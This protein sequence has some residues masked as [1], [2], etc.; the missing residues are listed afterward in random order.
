MVIALLAYVGWL[1]LQIMTFWIPYV[2]GASPRWARV[3]AAN[4]AQTVQWL[5]TKGNHLP[6]DASHF[7]L[8]LLLVVAIVCTTLA[9]RAKD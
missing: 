8:Q 3:H 4:F 9:A 2:Q 7:V 5:P 1:V 6:P